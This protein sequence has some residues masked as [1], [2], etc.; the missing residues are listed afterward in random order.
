VNEET[1]A[2]DGFEGTKVRRFMANRG[3]VVIKESRPIGK[4]KGIH[5]DSVSVETMIVMIGKRDEPKMSY[6]VKMTRA[7]TDNVEAASLYLDFDELPEFM[8]ALRYIISTAS[9]LRAQARDYTEVTYVTKDG[10]EFGFYQ[11][12]AGKQQ[13]Y[14][15]L[16]AVNGST[17]F[18][19]N[20]LN[21]LRE[22]FASA[23]AHLVSRGAKYD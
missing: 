23:E 16:S 9:Q 14:S 8:D 10:A 11:T 15:I 5:D 13:A 20:V 2:L 17:F 19:V 4:C 7:D 3:S 22:L 18:Q 6:G 12:T 21:S 1:D